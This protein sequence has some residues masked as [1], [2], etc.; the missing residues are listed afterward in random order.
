MEENGSG[1][2][3][4]LHSLTWAVLGSGHLPATLAVE[5]GVGSFGIPQPLCLRLTSSV[6]LTI[7]L[8]ADATVR[9]MHSTPSLE[10]K[11]LF[12]K[13]KFIY[14]FIFGCVG[15]LLLCA[16]L[17][18]VSGGYSLL[19]CTGFS[20]QWLLLLWSTDSRCVGFSSCGSR[21]PEGRFSSC[22]AWA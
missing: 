22:G 16:G 13:N 2:E 20:L 9:K 6:A 19:P 15:S 18:E 10:R 1:L 3:S 4:C 17:V 21:A 5:C 14:L 12:K 7:F 8:Y 11:L